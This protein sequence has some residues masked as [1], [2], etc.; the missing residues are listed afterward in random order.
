MNAGAMRLWS[1]YRKE[2]V[3]VVG[4]AIVA[5]L[6][7]ASFV[8]HWIAPQN[9]YDLASLNLAHTQLP[10]L[11]AIDGAYYLLGTDAQGRDLLS[12]V[13]YGL[14]VSFTVAFS[15]A[16]AALTIGTLLGLTAAFRGGAV[17][18][19]LMRLVD[20]HLA[21][22][23]IL[24]ALFLLAVFGRG[25]DKVI[26]ALIIVQWAYYARTVRASALSESAKDYVAATRVLR[27]PMMRVILRHVLPN[28]LPPLMVIA[29]IQLAHA[30]MLEAT[31]SFLG[32]G[33]S[34][35]QPSLGMLIA[36]GFEFLISGNYW[37]SVLPGCFL[38]LTIVA[39]NMVADRLRTI[40]NPRLR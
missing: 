3:A 32:L 27:L 19:A 34:I 18:A 2:R 40:F 30:V 7:G 21:I 23:T 24:V 15:S 37:I 11:T 14:R 36:N 10:P 5:I 17:D 12:A 31:L 25:I 9:P 39:L 28:C 20:M 26:L 35:T 8:S 4:M 38:L 16:A 6:L 29:A 1:E 22:P 13:M 33:V